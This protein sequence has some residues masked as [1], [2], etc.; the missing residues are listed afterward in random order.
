MLKVMRTKTKKSVC[1]MKTL[2]MPMALLCS[3][4]LNAEVVGRYDGEDLQIEGGND[5]GQIERIEFEGEVTSIGNMAFSDCSALKSITIPN[6]VKSIGNWA[7]EGCKSLTS[8]E[9][10]DSVTS[11]GYE[12]FMGCWALESITIPDSVNSI[13][14][15]AFL[16]CDSL[17]SI[18]LPAGFQDKKID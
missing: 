1:K 4:L 10:P 17:R 16:G 13:G 6:S 11:I 3:S 18:K 9:I 12:A 5:R 15:D 8:I 14:D 7:F 2:L